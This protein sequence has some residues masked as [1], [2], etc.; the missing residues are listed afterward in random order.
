[1]QSTDKNGGR[2]PTVL[3]FPEKEWS[4]G[5]MGN[6]SGPRRKTHRQ[7]A[8]KRRETAARTG[9]TAENVNGISGRYVQT[10]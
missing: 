9:K 4:Y 3:E 5:C 8:R 2:P 7:G 1:M 10:P 6:E